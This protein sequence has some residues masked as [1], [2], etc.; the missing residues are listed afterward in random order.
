ML[1]FYLRNLISKNKAIDNHLPPYL[2]NFE[3]VNEKKEIEE[4]MDIYRSGD[5]DME[6]EEQLI[7]KFSR[8]ISANLDFEVC[9]KTLKYLGLT[10]V[11]KKYEEMGEANLQALKQRRIR[12]A[13]EAK[14]DAKFSEFPSHYYMGAESVE[15]EVEDSNEPK[16]ADRLQVPNAQ[17][18]TK[19]QQSQK[20]SHD[21]E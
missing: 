21:K 4:L 9:S 18:Q 15:S 12:Q 5:Y 14:E 19:K 6:L 1:A 16:E 13:R 2:Q 8:Q 11:I 17:S 7:N 20:H 3:W 10:G